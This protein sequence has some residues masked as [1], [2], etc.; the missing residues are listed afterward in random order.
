M[1]VR[2]TARPSPL[3]HS[4][5]SR[6]AHGARGAHRGR[7]AR[8]A[9]HARAVSWIA[10]TIA[11][12]APARFAAGAEPSR[13][14]PGAWR[15]KVSPAVLDRA[16]REPAAFF[17][18]L[19]EQA[20]VGAAA[21]LP[22]KEAKGAFVV[23]ALRAMAE[24]T[25]API[26]RDLELRAVEHR[27]LWLVNAIWVRGGIDEVERMARRADVA[28][29]LHDA[30]GTIASASASSSA[31][32]SA[33]APASA[34]EWNLAWIDA[35]SVWAAGVTG[36]GAVVGTLDT[37][38]EWQHAAVRDRYR[39]WDGAAA[40]HDYNWHDAIHGPIQGACD[41]DSPEPCDNDGHGTHTTGT[42]V[43]DD[44]G[45]NQIGVAPGAQWIGCR[46]WEPAQRTYAS[47]CLECFEWMLAPTDM[48]NQNP[49]PAKAPHVINNSWM[50]EPVEGCVDVEILRPAVENLRAAGVMVVA[51]A[52]NDGPGCSTIWYP[53]AIYDAVF[54]VGATRNNDTAAPFSS[55]GPV[56]VDGSD[57][58]KP[59]I[60]A[61]GV[62]IRSAN[63]GG[64]YATW[65][66]TSMAGPH[67]A[68]L[69]ALLVSANPALAGQI[70]MLEQII[71]D[72]A[73]PRPASQT[74]GGV[75][76]TEIPN[77]TFGYGRID[78]YA[79]YS[80]AIATAVEGG[81]PAPS[82]AP[83]ARAALDPPAPNPAP[84]S[85]QIR[86]RLEAPA[87]VTLTIIDASG[88]RVRALR[89]RAD[90]PAGEHAA[91]WDGF[92]DDGSRAASGVYFCRLRAGG[93]DA[94]ER[95]TIVR[96]R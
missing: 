50:C 75:P 49:D 64:T 88:R 95:L 40:D 21:A 16:A 30:R 78:A 84:G 46:L 96:A 58:T 28:R 7:P 33:S 90:E 4:R 55:R 80:R 43:G 62:G 10:V 85:A 76:G 29:L 81:A 86:Y 26:L 93:V 25:Q 35:P 71:R 15:E 1:I 87:E 23:A 51:S 65:D 57:R 54:T 39:G 2:V 79:A 8:R 92:A 60:G 82:P 77:N 59:D 5:R 45:A 89:D 42:M 44:G 20:D 13:A 47:Y 22:T 37:G 24:R 67:V 63:L 91:T 18:W 68:G 14:E 32:A 70:D 38:V 52:G 31:T 94:T 72:S 17:V 3:Q 27:R 48:S 53:P 36:A 12:A 9:R 34:I 56:T 11:L 66:G 74:C 73:V 69:V 83:A 6:L 41:G 19:A 61:P